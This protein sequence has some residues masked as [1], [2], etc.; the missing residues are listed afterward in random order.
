MELKFSDEEYESIEKLAACNYSPERI[1]LYLGVEKKDFL[2]LWYN[3]S[4]LVRFHYDKG[5]LEAEADINIKQLELAK[6]GNITAAQT[7]FKESE[8]IRIKNIL[9]QIL[10]GND[11]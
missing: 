7:Y 6:S 8:N 3:K 2:D 10:Y 11:N 5:R 9:N 1:A 4:G